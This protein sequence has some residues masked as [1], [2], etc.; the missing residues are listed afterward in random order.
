MGLDGNK[1]L[2]RLKRLSETERFKD[3]KP[4][5][6]ALFPGYHCPL[7]G[8]ML[9]INNIRESV[10]L[11]LGPDECAYYT[12]MA[13]GGN[14]AMSAQGC[15]IVSVV[16][17]QHD[18]TFGC[19]ETLTEAFEELA[20]EYQPKAVFLVATCV[21]EVTGDDVE[22]LCQ[23]MEERYGFPIMVVHAENF[24]TDDHLPGIERTLEASF[25]LMRS[26]A[27]DGSVNILGLR[28][29][30]FRRTEV[31]TLLREAG[32]PL[33]MILPGQS[34]VEEITEA[35]KA[36]VNLVVHP[37]GLPLAERMKDA[38]G[39]P[40]VVFERYSD[41]E[42][43][44]DC[45]RSLFSALGKPV[46]GTVEE[47]CREAIARTAKAREALQGGSYFSGNTALANWEFH[48]FL[49]ERLGMKGLLI[50]TSK[51]DERDLPYKETILH[52]AD[53]YLSRAA[54]LGAL[55]YLYPIL[56]PDYNIGA[57][58]PREMAET[59][60]TPVTMPRAYNTLG[61]EVTEMVTDAFLAARSRRAGSGGPQGMSGIPMGMGGVAGQGSQEVRK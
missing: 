51:F 16:L 54:N 23:R 36:A 53:P 15:R 58:N 22:S 18:V 10:M 56:R 4:L 21:P 42:R 6:Y 12:K 57:G 34:S 27:T 40:Y 39:T 9:T 37:V 44:R 45:Y 30:D 2:G 50:Q 17:G 8:A 46:P 11:V 33:G 3:I 24:R 47:K 5:S 49:A 41:P 35:P 31:C 20:R 28:L 25:K 60:T 32:V 7:M 19:Q 59:G 38:F 55:K 26:Q 1:I 43:I 52:T 48:G 13:T 61:F 14:G 29:G